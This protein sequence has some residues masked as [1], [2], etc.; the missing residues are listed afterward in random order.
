MR[1]APIAL[2]CHNSTEQE[3]VDTAKDM[4]LL[5]HANRLGY[6]GTV[7]QVNPIHTYS[8]LNFLSQNNDKFSYAQY[9][10]ITKYK[11]DSFHDRA[12]TSLL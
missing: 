7:L 6:N 2:F 11:F 3:L 5:T 12:R 8:L 1:A 9:S 4:A 10:D